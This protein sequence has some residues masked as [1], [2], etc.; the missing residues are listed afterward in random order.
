MGSLF[1]LSTI[2]A[3]ALNFTN[4]VIQ[5]DCSCLAHNISANDTAELF[6]LNY[7]TSLNDTL[8]LPTHVSASDYPTGTVAVLS[9]LLF[10]S[11]VLNVFLYFIAFTTVMFRRCCRV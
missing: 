4:I 3:K 10:T 6:P 2:D 5:T 1:H 11:A 7:S 9:V 8:Q